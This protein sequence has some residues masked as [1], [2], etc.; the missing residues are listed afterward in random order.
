LGIANFLKTFVKVSS[1]EVKNYCLRQLALNLLFK[2]IFWYSLL[3]PAVHSGG[4]GREHVQ[5]TEVPAL[6]KDNIGLKARSYPVRRCGQRTSPLK[7]L[8]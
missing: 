7:S 6:R 5:G 3:S 2:D 4:F 8:L 1:R